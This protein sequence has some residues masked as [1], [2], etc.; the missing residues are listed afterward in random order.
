MAKREAGVAELEKKEEGETP[1]PPREPPKEK[2]PEAPSI[3][4]LRAFISPKNSSTRFLVER[5]PDLPVSIGPGGE[6]TRNELA[7]QD[8]FAIFQGG[9]CATRNPIIISWLVAH[10]T[11]DEIAHAKYHGERSQAQ[12]AEAVMPGKCSAFNAFRDFE[13]PNSRM[14]A[15]IEFRKLNLKNRWNQLPKDYS[16]EKLLAG[17]PP[18]NEFGDGGAYGT[19]AAITSNNPERF[20]QPQ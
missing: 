18:S 13:D 20:H 14:W 5:G 3:P 8:L 11:P 6:K 7:R 10:S 15:D 1:E 9:V 17:E 2:T 16:V 19:A 4:T 12:D